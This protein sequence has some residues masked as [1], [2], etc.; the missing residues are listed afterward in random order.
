MEDHQ[1]GSRERGAGGDAVFDVCRGPVDGDDQAEVFGARSAD[2]ER[3]ARGAMAGVGG[4]GQGAVEEL[5]EMRSAVAI[6]IAGEAGD[7]TGGR[8]VGKR[9]A[10]AA[11][12]LAV[13]LQTGRLGRGAGGGEADAAGAV[14]RQGI[15]PHVGFE[16]VWVPPIFP[17]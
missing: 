13:E 12:G 11:N 10:A 1:T 4:L 5:D 6:G 16:A 3:A 7:A 15:A 14:V 8:P 17:P 2:G 9:G